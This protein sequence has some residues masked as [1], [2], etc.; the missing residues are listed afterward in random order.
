MVEFDAEWHFLQNR[1]I[2]TLYDALTPLLWPYF[3][4]NLWYGANYLWSQLFNIALSTSTS[5][6]YLPGILLFSTSFDLE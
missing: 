1:T 6:R 4:L 3:V 5:T 2:T